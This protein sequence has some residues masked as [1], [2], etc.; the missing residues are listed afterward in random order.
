MKNNKT[1]VTTSLSSS[2]FSL[3]FWVPP[4]W[5]NRNRVNGVI[6]TVGSY[7]CHW[8]GDSNAQKIL[9]VP[10]CHVMVLRKSL[11]V[12]MTLYGI[13]YSPALPLVTASLLLSKGP[14][15][16][17]GVSC[18]CGSPL[19]LLWWAW[20]LQWVQRAPGGRN[21]QRWGTGCDGPPSEVF[22]PSFYFLW[23]LWDLCLHN[24]ES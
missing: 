24:V 8:P 21:R 14:W 3:C 12:I 7:L 15:V 10:G 2:T 23:I 18:S 5:G 6:Y 20:F 22:L 9:K 13:C 1:I 11:L 16:P 19:L 4:V 17:M